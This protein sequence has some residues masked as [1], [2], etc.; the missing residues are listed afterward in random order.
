MLQRRPARVA[1]APCAL[2]ARMA[3]AI[4]RHVSPSLACDG[5]GT[6]AAVAL[7]PAIPGKD[8][9]TCRVPDG[10]RDRVRPGMRVVVPIGRRHETGVVVDLADAPPDG[11][12]D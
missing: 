1:D 3:R 5:A 6:F 8:L 9:L 12:S 10:D 2:T 11:V 7:V 4:P